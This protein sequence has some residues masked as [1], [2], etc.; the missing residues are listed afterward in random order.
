MQLRRGSPVW[1]RTAAPEVGLVAKWTAAKVGAI[2][3]LWSA[4]PRWLGR[5]LDELS[6]AHTHSLPGKN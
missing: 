2:G 1:S 5:Y 4:A 6:S 3:S